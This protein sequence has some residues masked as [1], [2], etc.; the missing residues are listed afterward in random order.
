MIWF[1]EFEN[2]QEGDWKQWR[3]NFASNVDAV[4]TFVEIFG[5]MKK[6][7]YVWI[8][9]GAQSAGINF[10]HGDIFIHL[11][12]FHWRLAYVSIVTMQIGKVNCERSTNKPD[13][14]EGYPFY[15]PG[16]FLSEIL[17]LFFFLTFFPIEWKEKGV[18]F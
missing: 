8:V 18:W 5:P 6:K 13:I 9:E 15:E 11:E 12:K 2:C 16:S 4:F 10:L 7:D 3:K 1:A 17:F 14:L